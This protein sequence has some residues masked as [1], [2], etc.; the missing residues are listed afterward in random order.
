MIT[1]DNIIPISKMRTDTKAVLK[2][3]KSHQPLYLFSRSAPQAVL[4]GID[5]YVSLQEMVED[6]ED[7]RDLE[8]VRKE[9]SSFV[10]FDEYIAKKN[11]R[12][13]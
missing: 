7:I 3:L 8:K 13:V 9:E 10:P 12:K 6:Y 4:L 11:A 5:D 1:K 2:K